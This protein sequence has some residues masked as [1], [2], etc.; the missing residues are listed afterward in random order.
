[1]KEL[2]LVAK[3]GVFSLLGDATNYF[4]SYVFLFVATHLLGAAALGGFF[5]AL[6]IAGLIGEFADAGTGQGLIYFG[7]KYETEKG[8]NK[9]FPVFRF[10]LAFTMLNSIILGALLFIFAPNLSAFFHK[11][12]LVWLLRLFALAMPI[13]AFWPVLYKYFVARF[14]IVEGILYGDVL[15]PILR[16]AFLLVFI[17]LAMNGYA[18]IGVEL[19]VGAILVLIGLMLLFKI[20]GK[21]IFSEKLGSSEAK[22]VLL[23][24]IP[25][26]PLNMARGERVIIIIVGFFMAAAEVGVFG[27]VLKL[28]AISQV[29]LTGLN[30]VFRPMVTKLYSENNFAT[31]SSI[32]KSITRWIFVLT[33]PFSYFFIFFPGPVLALFGEQFPA[34]AAALAIVSVGYL[35]EF[36]T[37][38]TQV[39]ISMT[40]RSWLSLF[41]QLACLL[42]IML[43]A[44]ALIPSYGML[45]AALAVSA[46]IITINLLRLFQSYRMVGFTPYSF[47]LLKPV[48]S[49]V[50][51]GIAIYLFFPAGQILSIPRFF[52]LAGLFLLLYGVLIFIL[53]ID[54][55]DRELFSIA[56]KR[57]LGT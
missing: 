20:W 10:V 23:Y 54:K 43:F 41:N 15:R 32:Y 46:G 1:M 9:S 25:F 52:I 45:G 11:P 16:V 28:A 3:G 35:F 13:R 31:L 44:F 8:E 47:Y 39:I 49:A 22:S 7:S 4:L 29:I 18:L 27:V 33:L 40:G 51:S 12:D 42:A 37:S 21:K 53:G 19:A 17:F 30:F 36:G 26:L 48:M 57:I 55:E 14:K 56:K 38:A 2:K 24:S 5:W 34:G 6:S 50:I